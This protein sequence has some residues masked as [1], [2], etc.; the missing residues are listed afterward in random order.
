MMRVF[1][2]IALCLVLTVFFLF[3]NPASAYFSWY[4]GGYRPILN[5]DPSTFSIGLDL[6][7]AAGTWGGYRGFYGFGIGSY[8]FGGSFRRLSFGG[9]RRNI[10]R[11]VAQQAYAQNLMLAKMATYYAPPPLPEKKQTIAELT[12]NFKKESPATIRRLDDDGEK[13]PRDTTISTDGSVVTS[14]Y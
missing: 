12:K 2:R 13:Q 1:M 6:S 10:A 14:Y 3:S 11:Y 7:R 8:G 4:S 9:G 5:A